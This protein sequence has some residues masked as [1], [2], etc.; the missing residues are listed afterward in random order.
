MEIRLHDEKE[1]YFFIPTQEGEK[2]PQ[3]FN[4]ETTITQEDETKTSKLQKYFYAMQEKLVQILKVKDKL[5]K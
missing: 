4:V 3:H 5:A 2:L 1:K